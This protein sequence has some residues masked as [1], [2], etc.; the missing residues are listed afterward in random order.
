MGLPGVIIVL[1]ITV[2][3]AVGFCCLCYA[4]FDQG[5]PFHKWR[6]NRQPLSPLDRAMLLVNDAMIDGKDYKV[7]TTNDRYGHTCVYIERNDGKVTI[8]NFENNGYGQYLDIRLDG[9]GKYRGSQLQPAVAE[10]IRDTC[11]K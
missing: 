4:A 7:K 6:R 9:M 2:C 3:A 5:G 10:L 11:H 8:E 1:A